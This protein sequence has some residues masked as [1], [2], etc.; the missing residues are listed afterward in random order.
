MVGALALTAGLALLTNFR[1]TGER[2]ARF[3]GAL[4]FLF[5]GGTT[6]RHRQRA[7]RTWGLVL[8]AGGSLAILV[9]I[10]GLT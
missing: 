7:Y 10:A 4:T 1:D 6:L 5:D 8:S 9:G 2:V 3:G